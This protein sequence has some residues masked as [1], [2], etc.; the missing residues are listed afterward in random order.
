M[1]SFFG[2]VA[3]EVGGTVKEIGQQKREERLINEEEA[4]RIQLE[5]MRMRNESSLLDRR[6]TAEDKRQRR[7][8][9]ADNLREQSRQTFETTR[10]QNRQQADYRKAVLQE[11]SDMW[12]SAMAAY[13]SRSKTRGMSGNGWDVKFETR[14]ELVDGRMVTVETAK[15][16]REGME[17]MALR[18]GKLLGIGQTKPPAQFTSVDHQI[19]AEED[20][21]KG[22]VTPE[23]FR[24]QFNYLPSDYVFG[25]VSA[26]DKGF[27]KFLETED[28][29]LPL[30][31]NFLRD[32]GKP[33]SKYPDHTMRIRPDDDTYDEDDPRGVPEL[34]PEELAQQ[35]TLEEAIPDSAILK[36]RQD[37]FAKRLRETDAPANTYFDR[38]PEG[39]LAHLGQAGLLTQGQAAAGEIPAPLETGGQLG[40]TRE[41]AAAITAAMPVAGP[42]APT[43]QAAPAAELSDED[44]RGLA[45]IVVNALTE[46]GKTAGGALVDTGKTV[47]DA[48]IGSSEQ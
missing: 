6:I 24:N 35:P 14:D 13:V 5:K 31:D 10:E 27:Q 11:Q 43:G 12:Q 32:T 22:V 8:I 38:G 40:P 46:A 44:A 28:I 26:T 20:L 15:V 29:R 42:P 34:P 23:E 33:P 19:R 25:Q 3:Q 48:L 1:A 9:E 21:M 4:R 41:K 37:A 2:S 30:F 16:F 45:S 17:P 39:H 7:K 36:E 18:D 47:G